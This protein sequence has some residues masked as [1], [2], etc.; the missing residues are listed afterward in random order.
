MERFLTDLAEIIPGERI[1]TGDGLMNRYGHVWHTDIPIRA[2]ALILPIST[3]EVSAI[4][5][6]CFKFNQKVVIHGGLTNLVGSTYPSPE[7][8]IISMEKMDKIEEVDI[9][10]RTMTV[11]SG[12]ILEQVQKAATARDMMFPLNF[13][14]KGSAQIG[15]IIATNA[16][17]LRVLKFGMMRQ[18]VIGLEAVLANG[19]VISSMKKI[20]KDNSGYDLKQL[21]IGS[22]GTLGI[23]TRATL[24]LVES[25][26][27][28]ISAFIGL[29]DYDDVVEFMKF[30]DKGL[31]GNLSAFELLWKDAYV[32]L[33]SYPSVN[34]P[35]IPYDYDYYVL[36]EA[37]GSNPLQDHHRFVDLLEE[38]TTRKMISEATIADNEASHQWFWSIR[39]DV[40][41]LLSHG[42]VEQSFD[43]S[44]PI[45]LIGVTIDNMINQLK[46]LDGVERIFPFGHVADGNIHFVISKATDSKD[47]TSQ[48]NDIVYSPIEHIGGSI[49]AEH[50]I[51]IDKKAYLHLCRSQTEIELMRTL[52]AALDPK[53]I[54][55]PG[56]IF[57]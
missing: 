7:D 50:G 15:G 49:S 34:R 31:A 28:R 32:G 57:S 30:M 17:G 16:G 26:S 44:I 53:G 20:I 3:R 46:G 37:M 45:P 6:I 40:F 27:S 13:G 29:N 14:A 5:Q 22:E 19:S 47:L 25:T 24:K 8:I 4:L 39:E 2:K 56:R 10:S 18:L 41:P 1:L 38:A 33:T 52:K 23:V 21:F 51:G 11:Q 35:P 42:K 9:Q 43:I 55:N 12:A 48:I 54:L 36:L